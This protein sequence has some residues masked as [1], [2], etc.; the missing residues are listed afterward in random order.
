MKP[1]LSAII[2]SLS[3]IPSRYST[4]PI[5]ILTFLNC[6]Y[7][8]FTLLS[9]SGQLMK[10]RQSSMSAQNVD[11]NTRSIHRPYSVY[12]S[13][14]LWFHILPENLQTV[15]IFSSL[16]SFCVFVPYQKQRDYLIVAMANEPGEAEKVRI[17]FWC[18][19]EEKQK[20]AIVCY[21]S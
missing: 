5:L 20:Q 17:A 1:V 9:S 2:L 10:D 11:T 12:H 21:R 19:Y 8:L 13:T 6:K 3:I 16:L 4:T 14:D 15:N 18:L 7:L